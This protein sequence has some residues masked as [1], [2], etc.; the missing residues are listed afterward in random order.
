LLDPVSRGPTC[1][2]ALPLTES[3]C[4]FPCP[5]ER[6]RSYRVASD[7]LI[8]AARRGLRQLQYR[9]DVLDGCLTGTG[10]RR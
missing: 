2:P 10:L 6:R 8:P 5:V 9:P 7:D 1:R 4:R 3:S